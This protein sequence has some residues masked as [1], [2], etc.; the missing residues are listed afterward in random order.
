MIRERGVGRED[1]IPHGDGILR[2]RDWRFEHVVSDN[3]RCCYL[4]AR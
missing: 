3:D 2:N 4:S 1:V